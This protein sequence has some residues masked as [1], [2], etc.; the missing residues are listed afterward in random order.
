MNIVRIPHTRFIALGDDQNL[1][2]KAIARKT[3]KLEDHV[4][5]L[6]VLRTL[7]RDDLVIDVGAFIGDTALIFLEFTDKVIA[8]EPQEDAYFCLC[9]NSPKSLNLNIAVG[10]GQKVVCQQD[11]MDGNLGTRTVKEG[12]DGEIAMA[13]DSFKLHEVALIKI[14]AEGFE[15]Q[16]LLGAIETIQR[17]RPKLVIEVY[18]EMLAKHSATKEDIYQI[19]ADVGY[20]HEVV[21]GNE[22]EPRWDILCLPK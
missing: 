21:I 2:P 22:S 3:I 13:L 10:A 11:P 18:P 7:K 14:D 4:W 8:F 5:A 9:Y 17:C 1:T 15:Y 12:D 20:V 6:P 19:L 16:V